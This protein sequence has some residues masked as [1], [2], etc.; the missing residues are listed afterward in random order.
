MTF[1]IFMWHDYHAASPMKIARQYANLFMW[2]LRQRVDSSTGIYIEASRLQRAV[3]G[4]CPDLGMGSGWIAHVPVVNLESSKLLWR[5]AGGQLVGD[6]VMMAGVGWS[7][8][9]ADPY[10]GVLSM[11]QPEKPALNWSL[12]NRVGEICWTE[13]FS[14]NAADAVDFYREVF[15]W[16]CRKTGL[17]DSA[18]WTISANGV[19]FAGMTSVPSFTGKPY[20]MP[21]MR[22]KSIK[23]ILAVPAEPPWIKATSA[24]ETIAQLGSIVQLQ[25]RL[26]G[27]IGLFQPM[28]QSPDIPN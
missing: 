24:V 27:R 3:A 1:G 17:S 5:E 21:Y 14:A 18:Y 12:T 7:Q 23:D 2:Q 28:A 8:L 22:V 26:G 25:D 6:S 16:D 11:Y 4:F 20:W 13:Y 15:G 10:G 19:D 9:V